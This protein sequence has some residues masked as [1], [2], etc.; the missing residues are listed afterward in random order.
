M[1]E[2]FLLMPA[3][4]RLRDTTV[5]SVRLAISLLRP[6]FRDVMLRDKVLVTSTLCKLSYVLAQ[7]PGKWWTRDH[8]EMWDIIRATTQML[9]EEMEEHDRALFEEARLRG[10]IIDPEHMRHFHG[11]SSCVEY[12]FPRARTSSFSGTSATDVD[13]SRSIHTLVE[14]DGP[15]EKP[16]KQI[17]KVMEQ[18]AI[19]ERQKSFVDWSAEVGEHARSSSPIPSPEIDTLSESSTESTPSEIEV[20]E[21]DAKQEHSETDPVLPIVHSLAETASCVVTSLLFGAFIMLCIMS[22]QRR[23]LATH[24]Y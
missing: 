1:S 4:L 19:D 24:I 11:H 9:I 23:V 12:A 15:P 16:E 2:I 20:S 8:S 22:S 17:L 6:W 7:W 18:L 5:G 10:V 13:D 14:V 3:E 21:D